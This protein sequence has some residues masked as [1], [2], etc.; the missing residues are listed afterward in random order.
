MYIR[1]G[2]KPTGSLGGDC[3]NNDAPGQ[4]YARTGKSNGRIGI[5]YSYYLPKIMMGETHRH[6]YVSAVVWVKETPD[7]NVTQVVPAGTSYYAGLDAF[8]TSISAST[9]Y[10]ALDGDSRTTHPVVGYRGARDL[11]PAKEG[12]AGAKRPPLIG[13]TMMTEAARAQFNGIKYEWAK[14]PFN[15]LNFQTYLDAAFNSNYYLGEPAPCSERPGTTTTLT[16]GL[17][18]ATP[19]P[20]PAGNDTLRRRHL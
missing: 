10:V 1:A 17:P 8:D 4:V 15:D 11:F 5:M 13:W 12:S 18:T 14:C 7:C 2:L 19:A 3:R 9:Q 20:S 6:Y 16:G